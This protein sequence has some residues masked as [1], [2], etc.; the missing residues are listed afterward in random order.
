MWLKMNEAALD[1]LPDDVLLKIISACTDALLR[2]VTVP[3]LEAVKGLSSASK[4]VRRQLYRLRPLVG[5]QVTRSLTVAQ[6][7]RRRMMCALGPWEVVL[8]F[9]GEATAMVVEQSR[10]GRV[11]SIDAH[12][13]TL[14]RDVASRVVPELLG[15]GSSLRVLGLSHVHLN[16]SWAATFGEAAVCSEELRELQLDGCQLCG[17]LP[18]LR[19]PKL[20]VLFLSRNRLT[21]SLEPLKGCTALR[22]LDVSHN[23]LSGSL[24]PLKSLTLLH[25]LDVSH[26]KLSGGLE[27]L[28]GCTGLQELF[29]SI[30]QLMGGLEPLK[31]CT[32]LCKL[33]ATF[34]KLSGGLEPL[35]GCTA[36]QRLDLTF[37]RLTGTLDPLLGCT[38]LQDLA[39]GNNQLEGGLEPLRDCTRLRRLY[40]SNNHLVGRVEPLA[41]CTVLQGLALSGNELSAGFGP[42][43]GCTALPKLYL[44]QGHVYLRKLVRVHPL[45]IVLARRA[46]FRRQHVQ[47]HDGPP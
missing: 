7:L 11:L 34:N 2:H 12:G 1:A 29:L 25:G 27:P 28:A 45:V 31:G 14:T 15:A 44:R 30:N 6:R 21:G 43:R 8:L 26:N 36:L 42:L 20:Q 5:V 41:A 17:P 23:F 32:V 16:D 9:V 19:L 13:T 33:D 47:N 4:E 22:E 40:L 35:A 18:N 3:K 46:Q 37:N 24:E 38:A 10:R 39:L